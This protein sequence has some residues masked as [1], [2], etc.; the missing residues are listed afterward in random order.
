MPWMS[1]WEWKPKWKSCNKNWTRN[2]P[3]H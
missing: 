2:N 3:E 1:R